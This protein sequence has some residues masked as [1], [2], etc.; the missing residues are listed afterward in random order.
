MTTFNLNDRQ[1]GNGPGRVQGGGKRRGMLFS[2]NGKNVSLSLPDT[3]QTVQGWS[4]DEVTD[5]GEDTYQSFA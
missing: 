4:A 3:G 1:R 2:R 5:E